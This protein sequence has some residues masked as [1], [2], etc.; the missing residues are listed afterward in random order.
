MARLPE[1]LFNVIKV[2]YPGVVTKLI[3]LLSYRILGSM[4][5][6]SGGA[7]LEANPVTHK[8]ATVA[9]VPISDDVPLSAFAYEIFHSLSAIG[10]SLRLTSDDVR[11]ALGQGILEPNY[12]YRLTSWLAQQEDRNIITLYQSDYAL[13]EWT[14]RCLRQSDV[15]IL[16]GLGDRT[17]HVGNFEKEIDKWAPRTQKELVLLHRESTQRP[18]NTLQ[19]LN[20]RPWVTNHHHVQCPNRMF[21]RKSQNKIV[22]RIIIIWFSPLLMKIIELLTKFLDSFVFVVE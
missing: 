9:L 8:F 13:T 14:R 1:G 10:P 21:T 16:V 5:S 11:K 4:Q 22:G 6:K 18:V 15:I 20:V 3:S 7:P 19:W 17:P 12:E 2:K